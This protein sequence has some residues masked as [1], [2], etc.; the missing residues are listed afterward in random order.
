MMVMLTMILSHNFSVEL[1]NELKDTFIFYYGTYGYSVSKLCGFTLKF[2]GPFWGGRPIA[3][4]FT[5]GFP[6]GNRR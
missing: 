5:M 2:V 4:P 1:T 6:Q 3:T